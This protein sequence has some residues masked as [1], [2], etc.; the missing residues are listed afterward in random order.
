MIPTWCMG[1]VNLLDYL[2]NWE[3]TW[4]PGGDTPVVIPCF[5][6]DSPTSR[7]A[8]KPGRARE[9]KKLCPHRPFFRCHVANS[10]C[11]GRWFFWLPILAI[12]HSI[13]TIMIDQWI[14]DEIGVDYFQT[15]MLRCCN[16][17]NDGSNKMF[18]SK[19]LSCTDDL[20]PRAGATAGPF[21]WCLWAPELLLFW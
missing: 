16:S 14:W 19:H 13:G 9:K 6:W 18:F 15:H 12:C 7:L 3:G 20:F 11:V 10:G 21:W 5:Q 8:G 2:K 17:H 1:Y 4:P